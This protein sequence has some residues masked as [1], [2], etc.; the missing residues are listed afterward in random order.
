M[1]V[2]TSSIRRC[3]QADKNNSEQGKCSLRICEQ[4]GEK[5]IKNYKIVKYII[6]NSQSQQFGS[7]WQE[8]AFFGST[9]QYFVVVGSNQVWYIIIVNQA[10]KEGHCRKRQCFSFD[11]TQKALLTTCA[12]KCTIESGGILLWKK[13]RFYLTSRRKNRQNGCWHIIAVYESSRK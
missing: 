9:W 13:A 8:K 12:L 7:T 2:E 10:D 1:G 3:P 11:K 6:F 5:D 4:I